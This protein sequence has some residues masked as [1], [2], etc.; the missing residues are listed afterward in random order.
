VLRVNALATFS[1][2][3]LLPRL[4]QFRHRHPEIEVRL[5]AGFRPCSSEVGVRQRLALIAIEKHDVAGFC[6]LLAQLQTQA[7]PIDLAGNLPPFQG[8]PRPPVT[9]L[10]FATPWTVASG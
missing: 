3:W 8:V 5:G 1:L 7:Y 10:F 6:L 9:E 2:R 4:V